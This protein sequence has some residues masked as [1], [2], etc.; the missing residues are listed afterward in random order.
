MWFKS[1]R[2]RKTQ[3]VLSAVQPGEGQQSISYQD[4][5]LIL[6]EWSWSSSFTRQHFFLEKSSMHIRAGYVLGKNVVTGWRSLDVLAII[7]WVKMLLSSKHYS[8]CWT[9]HYQVYNHLLVPV[10]HVPVMRI[11]LTTH[12]TSQKV[13]A[14]WNSPRH[15]VLFLKLFLGFYAFFIWIGQ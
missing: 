3:W 8:S 9:D 13:L 4:E 7:S 14:S 11:C 12:I 5:R 10:V 1:C 15:L 2:C 6:L